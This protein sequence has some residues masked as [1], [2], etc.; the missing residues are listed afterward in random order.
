MVTIQ[1]SQLSTLRHKY[2]EEVKQID[3]KHRELLY[4]SRRVS[5]ASSISPNLQG[6][7][8]KHFNSI[9][10]MSMFPASAAAA[11]GE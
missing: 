11:T 4:S 2:Y 7:Q 8:R 6:E 1:Q 10:M 5:E 9:D 3:R